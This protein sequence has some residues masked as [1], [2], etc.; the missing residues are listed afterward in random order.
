MHGREPRNPLEGG[1]YGIGIGGRVLARRGK[2]GRRRAPPRPR[3]QPSN[4]TTGFTPPSTT[5]TPQANIP[6][7]TGQSS[8]AA[9]V[10]KQYG[11]IVPSE[12]VEPEVVEEVVEEVESTSPEIVQDVAIAAP[13]ETYSGLENN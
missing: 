1:F 2:G 4:Q 9:P 3:P 5:E 12:V 13:E 10:Q 8:P 6:T 7:N 11:D